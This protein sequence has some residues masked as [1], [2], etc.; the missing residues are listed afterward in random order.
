M[1]TLSIA[2]AVVQLSS[3]M[4]AADAYKISN[5]CNMNDDSAKIVSDWMKEPLALG[6]GFNLPPTGNCP[7]TGLGWRSQPDGDA[8]GNRWCIQL[9]PDGTLC[10]ST[11]GTCWPVDAVGG[12]IVWRWETCQGTV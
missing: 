1:L 9:K 7:S 6:A 3:F 8:N 4:D 5:I 12:N 10:P 11:L 2:A